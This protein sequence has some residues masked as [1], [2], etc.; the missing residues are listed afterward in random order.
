MNLLLRWYPGDPA[1]EFAG[2]IIV[3]IGIVIGLG[4]ILAAILLRRRPTARHALWLGVLIAV[5]L[6]PLTLAA[7][8]RAGW[9]W[10]IPR[11]VS[12]NE[13]ASA[14]DP[15]V[16][17]I[18][19]EVTS[20]LPRPS[21][22]PPS[23][24][25]N[26]PAIADG[27]QMRELSGAPPRIVAIVP[28]RSP[29]DVWRSLA[30][31]GMLVW[32]AGMA[33]L[34]VR[35]LRG[36]RQVQQLLA[37]AEPLNAGPVA[38]A[39]DIA[40][41][42]LGLRTLPPIVLSPDLAGPVVAGLVRPTVVLPADFVVRA[43]ASQ[44]ADVLIHECSHVLRW[45]LWVGLAQRLVQLVFWP[46]PLV[47][48]MNRRLSRAREEVCD[49]YVLRRGDAPGYAQTLLELASHYEDRPIPAATLAIFSR[50]WNLEDRV[51][52][53]LD[54]HRQSATRFGPAKFALLA[55]LLVAG[56][57][58]L[59]AVK[60]AEPSPKPDT[61]TQDVAPT[62]AQQPAGPTAK[63]PTLA[64][65]RAWYVLSQTDADSLL[66]GLPQ[67]LGRA[68][69]LDRRDGP[70]WQG[71]DGGGQ[72]ELDITVEG[73]A[74][75]EIV[76]GF[77]ESPRWWLAEPVQVRRFDKPGHYTVDR[78]PPGKFQVGAMIGELPRP[79]SL[80]VHRTWPEPLTITAGKST[81]AALR[82]SHKFKDNVFLIGNLAEGFA[83][84]W[85][86]IDPK[87]TVTIQS[88]DQSGEPVPF[89][90]ITLVERQADDPTKIHFYHD[91]GTNDQGRAYFEL[92]ALF[93][94][95]YQRFDFVPETMTSR[96]QYIREAKGFD[97]RRGPF[98]VKRTW[99]EFPVGTGKVRG[100]IHDQHGRALTEY[101]LTLTR[102]EGAD[103]LTNDDAQTYGLKL[104]I[105]DSDGRFEV[106]DLA[107]GTYTLMV[108]H[109]D[110]VTHVSTFD[111]PK[112][113]VP[114]E[115]NAEVEIDVEVEAKE[116]RYGRAVFDDGR[117]V[118]PGSHT[119]WFTR[120]P[121]S[122]W[123]G[124]SFSQRTEKDGS[125]RVALS[126]EERR[127]LSENSAGL[128]EVRAFN[129]QHQTIAEVKVPFENLSENP[130][131]PTKVV[132]PQPNAKKAPGENVEDDKNLNTILE[133]YEKAVR[134]V[135]SY[136]ITYRAQ[137][138]P[139]LVEKPDPEREAARRERGVNGRQLAKPL[140]PVQYVA[141]EP[142]AK[143]RAL[144]SRQHF[145]NGQF[146]IESLQGI[147]DKFDV[148][149]HLIVWDGESR[150]S[151]NG[152]R[153]T[154][155][156]QST[157]SD[158]SLMGEEVPHYEL[159]YRTAFGNYDY[160]QIV[161]DRDSTC[162]EKDG[163]LEIEA[164]PAPK[165]AVNLNSY[166]W[167][168]LLD[169]H[170]NHMP[171]RITLTLNRNEQV[172]NQTQI[173]N[174]L[175][176]VRPGV[177][178]PVEAVVSYF[179]S[180]PDSPQFG[181]KTGSWRYILDRDA[182]RFNVSVDRDLFDLRFPKG[183]V[184]TDRRIVVD[185]PQI[186]LSPVEEPPRKPERET[187]KLFFGAQ[188]ETTSEDTQQNS[189]VIVEADLQTGRTRKHQFDGFYRTPRISPDGQTVIYAHASWFRGFDL[190]R[191][192]W[193]KNFAGGI[194]GDVQALWLPNG[195][196]IVVSSYK[197]PRD[198]VQSWETFKVN[199]DGSE[200]SVLAVPETELATDISRDGQWLVTRSNRFPP[201]DRGHQ[202]YAMRLDGTESRRLTQDG[203]N[204]DARIS[205]DGRRVAYVRMSRG[206]TELRIINFDGTGERTIL[207]S[208]GANNAI[209][210]LAWSPGGERLA[211]IRSRADDA[212]YSLEIVYVD[213]GTRLRFD[214]ENT[215]FVTLVGLDWR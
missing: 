89:C 5:A 107:A 185:G 213:E 215:V 95:T 72:V 29:R 143:G 123:G 163:L 206:A 93:S 114:D 189:T 210:S 30:S 49:N 204:R 94:L 168:L 97:S 208:D 118:H 66:Y 142:G 61:T 91:V 164:L 141:A 73:D 105:T 116:L 144:E 69:E 7:C 194:N 3:E 173:D 6:S 50:R 45:D 137:E 139:L 9:N 44:L 152:R 133:A 120:D 46:H 191:V 183:T 162:T 92:S 113:T 161:K 43:D 111:G 108:R 132:V 42:T 82:V 176:E 160:S 207:T 106:K 22:D 1:I 79:A 99:D 124:K 40:C 41:R 190:N 122:P 169:P 153:G 100:R 136:D 170:A 138:T 37:Q 62:S 70:A 177:W 48:F 195:R 85:K 67:R 201:H 96:Y 212:K 198:G 104:P 17:P 35:L 28:Q 145:R 186:S 159:F 202:I 131:Q 98:F 151:F 112:V 140:P 75:G 86:E 203:G 149:Q 27:E 115:A 19:S 130:R 26:P 13:P 126:R 21:A 155:L 127:L 179:V 2:R 121:N 154:A 184:V 55:A 77:F 135:L 156:V 34:L 47:H 167:R 53:I 211:V 23:L 129:D 196:S 166:G 38:W 32:L 146:R 174:T 16:A 165:R 187:G 65:S 158:W 52:G 172:V 188:L 103:R 150:K 59:A 148:G 31:V 57:S 80:G 181:Q 54:P 214:L 88:S 90:R 125:F 192:P 68:S 175:E 64:E 20:E 8:H 83:G 205:P 56:G 87:K 128:I 182:C 197:D 25:G 71:V 84:K 39:R 200:R 81:D 193:Y 178:L 10:S 18:D 157:A 147:S 11:P 51:A 119:A 78:L 24:I 117:P 102:H 60:V 109:F 58:A 36:D 76:V 33:F 14:T 110:S 12:V 4:G 171:K 63:E 15:P 74:K 199:L 209:E 180:M 134:K 101:F